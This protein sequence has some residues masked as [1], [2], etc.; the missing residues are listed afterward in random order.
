[1]KWRRFVHWGIEEFA[2]NDAMMGPFWGNLA[3]IALAGSLTLACFAA[4]LRLLLR[5]GE[6]DPLHPKYMILRD[7]RH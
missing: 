5:P 7:E 2:M 3:V 1:M 4:A 6:R